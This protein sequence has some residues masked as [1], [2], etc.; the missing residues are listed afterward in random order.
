MADQERTGVTTM[1]GNPLTLIGPE[2]KPGDKAPEFQ[3]VAQDMSPVGLS[4]SAGKTRLLIAVPS[5]DTPVCSLETVRFNREVA[6]VGGNVQVYVISMDLPFAQ[7]RFCGS[8]GI[9]NFQTL[10]DHRDASF[11]R[12]YG[13]LIK[14]LRLLARALFVVDAKDT[15][16]YVQIVPEVAQEPNYDEALSALRAATG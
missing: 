3:A 6:Q 13:V 12:A 11:G 9:S 14:D 4:N 5:L 15:I 1:R 8:E 2:L 7:K 16:R 10:S